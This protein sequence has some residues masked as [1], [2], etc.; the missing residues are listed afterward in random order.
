MNDKENLLSS[1]IPKNKAFLLLQLWAPKKVNIFHPITLLSIVNIE[2][3][4][5]NS[6][7]MRL[8]ILM[9][10]HQMIK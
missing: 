3:K 8:I 1:T 5:I 10:I 4:R 2:K 7:S 9:Y 6:T